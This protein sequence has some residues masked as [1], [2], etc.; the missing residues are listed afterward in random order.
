MALRSKLSLQI[1]GNIKTSISQRLAS[2]L[3]HSYNFP[4]HPEL[5]T[6]SSK[7]SMHSQRLNSSLKTPQSTSSSLL[8]HVFIDDKHRITTPLAFAEPP[9]FKGQ[10]SG[11]AYSPSGFTSTLPDGMGLPTGN[12][13]QDQLPGIVSYGLGAPGFLS[14]YE[15]YS[16]GKTSSESSAKPRLVKCTWPGCSRSVQKTNLT[17]HV[18]ETHR[19][20]VK[21]VCDN[22]GRGFTR[23]YMLK[24]HTCRSSQRHGNLLCSS[25]C[26]YK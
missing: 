14:Q 15:M 1:D 4:Y 24:N 25:Q 21:A 9:V 6:Q 26:V 18:N 2:I 17:R 22:C 19:R 7:M 16:D 10:L 5:A 23:P 8:G 11:P 20:V 13:S 3:L 12:L